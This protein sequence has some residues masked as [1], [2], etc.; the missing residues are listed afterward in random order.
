MPAHS[1]KAGYIL[2]IPPGHIQPENDPFDN[3]ADVHLFFEDGAHW[4]S[5]I[6]TYQNLYTMQRHYAQTGECLGGA[7]FCEPHMLIID[8]LTPERIMQ[9]VDDL[10]TSNSLAC[11][12]EY[13]GTEHR[14]TED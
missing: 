2:W 12:F 4:V 3:N 13:V 10:I 8:Q 7:Y 6:H 1:S 11:A 5:T 9:I 14:V